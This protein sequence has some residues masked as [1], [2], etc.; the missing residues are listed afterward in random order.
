MSTNQDLMLIR[1]LVVNHWESHNRNLK[2]ALNCL[3]VMEA[4]SLM[5]INMKIIWSLTQEESLSKV[6]NKILKKNKAK[7]KLATVFWWAHNK[8]ELQTHSLASEKLHEILKITFSWTIILFRMWI[9]LLWSKE[10][11]ISLWHTCSKT[12]WDTTATITIIDS[13]AFLTMLK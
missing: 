8:K 3:E 6:T 5:T 11:L 13:Q 1:Y 7:G 10:I 4:L 12:A 9:L 2:R